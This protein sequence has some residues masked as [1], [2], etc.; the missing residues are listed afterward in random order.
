MEKKD[1]ALL[2]IAGVVLCGGCARFSP[3]PLSP[4][5]SAA[6]FESRTLLNPELK[7]FLEANL[8][9][10]ITPWPAKSWDINMLVLA[11]VYYH[12]DLDLA[13]STWGVTKAGILTAGERPNPTFSFVPQFVSNA[14]AGASP[15]L[16]TPT[17]DFT[18]ETA[19]KRG[20]R[21]AEAEHLAEAA[22][23]NVAS[24]A[25]K[26][27]SRLRKSLLD[28]Y[29]PV[30]TE[31]LL[32]EQRKVQEGIVRLLEQRLAV[33]EIPQPEVTQARIALNQLDLSLREAQ[34]Q[35]AEA[36][37]QVA[38]SLGVPTAA[39]D[40]VDLN[41]DFIEQIPGAADLPSSAVQRDALM[42]RP[43]LLSALADYAASESA[44]QIEIAKQYPDLHLNPGYEFD[45]G[46]NKWGLGFSLTL[47]LLNRNEGPIAE[48]EAKRK[49]AAAKFFA[50][51][52]Q[53][54]GEIQRTIAGYRGALDKL[55]TADAL[56]AA[57]NEQQKSVQTMFNAGEADQ[58]TLL[59]ADLEV[60]AIAIS[61]LDALVK[62]RQSFDLLEDAVQFPLSG[63][64]FVPG[65]AEIDSRAKK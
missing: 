41:F 24:A 5:E 30:E 23:L 57:Q 19:G 37:A 40:E 13:R 3:Q 51:Q 49:E 34:R 58:L 22:R 32:R 27:R 7:K 12:P 54:I 64:G 14:A 4:S 52:A 1:I 43:D 35:L 28:L 59:S 42:S 11:A 45:Q 39:L 60:D 26:V 25:W 50:L 38:D 16:F 36:R 8:H 31:R 44:L 46:A 56:L 55:K 53:V 6:S 65:A 48:A 21:I 61:R 9:R 47:P 17:L 33:G 2:A 15:W 63:A 62:A 18:A 20:Y 10:E 29:A